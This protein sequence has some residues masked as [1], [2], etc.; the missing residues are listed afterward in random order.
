MGKIARNALKGYSYQHSVF[1]L[2]LSIMDTE[3]S[4]NKITVEA[5]NTKNFD[6][7]Y[8][9][10]VPDRKASR[11]TYR[12]QVKNYSG[13]TIEDISITDHIL[14]IKGDSNEFVPTDNNI[15]VVNTEQIVA[16]ESFMGLPCTRLKGIIIIPL[17]PEQIA[18]KLDNM[19][20]SET[21]ELQIIHKA[22]SIVQNA[23]F[24]ISVA[25]LPNLIEMSTDL[26]NNTVLLRKV[27]DHFEHSI[28]FIEGKP[29]VGKSHFVNEI[30]EKHPDAIVY[31]FWTG[32]QDPNINRRIQFEVFISELGIK[33]FRSAK[34]VL[35]EELID[36]IRREDKLV[37]FDGLDHVENYNPQ[38][39]ELFLDFINKLR[40]TRTVVLSRPLRHEIPWKKENLLDWTR[41]ETS[42][43]LEIA[44]G[45]SEYRI[46][47]QIFE[48]SGGYPIITYFLAEEF[49]LNHEIKSTS[50]ITG[51]NDYYDTLFVSNE[52]PSAAISIFATGNCFFTWNE[53]KS[54]FTE[55][56]MYDVIRE[57]VSNHPYLFRVIQN[58]ISLIHD[59]LNTYL[60]TKVD[61]FEQRQAKTVAIVRDSLLSGS[62]EYM[63]RMESFELDDDFYLEMIKK[64]SN[65]NSLTELMLSTRDYNSISSLYVQLQRL[66]E[67]RAGVL[68]IYEYYSFALLFQI[69]TRNDLFGHDSLVY[70]M[71]LYMNSH[72]GIEDNIFSSDYIWHVYLV[73]KGAEKYA[74]RYLANKNMSDSQFYGLID[75]LNKESIFYEK[76]DV[77]INYSEFEAVLK[78]KQSNLINKEN[79]LTDYLI[80]LWIHGKSGDKY[81]DVFKRYVAGDRESCAEITA[82]MSQYDLDKHWTRRSLNDA[83][84]QL[85]ELGFLEDNNQ[86]R[87][88]TLHELIM[89][90]APHG[91]FKVT[92]M[93]ASFLKLANH[94]NREIDISSLAYCWSMYYNRK[95]YSVLT[96]DE[97]LLTFES[98]GLISWEHSF[99][100]IDRLMEQ[101]EKGISH[102]LTS[103]VNKKD[104]DC[105]KQVKETGYF[106]NESSNIR[107]WDLNPEH[108]GC[109]ST[110][111]VVEQVIRLLGRHYYSNK[112]EGIILQNI[113]NSGHRDLVLSGIKYYNYVVLMPDEALIPML[114]NKGIEYE[115]KNLE[116]REES[117]PE[118]V[119]FHHGYI[120]ERDFGYIAEHDIGCMEIA[121]YADGWCSCLPF[122]DLFSLFPKEEIQENH[123][124]IIHNSLFARVIDDNFIGNW[125]RIIGNIPTFLSK[126]EIDVDW[127]KIYDTFNA[128]LDLSMINRLT[129]RS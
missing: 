122:V 4:I 77:V 18:D 115:G 42:V 113:V 61:Y 48:I 96:I 74:E 128:F 117:E 8:F 44:Y 46:Q 64:Y 70:Q 91:S 81:F 27:P 79:A 125:Y 82:D 52:K 20:F 92:N 35:I 127:K 58:R 51:I 12:V 9:E 33:V 66:L 15:L 107:F 6:D 49:K 86:F 88:S 124:G 120:S 83:E 31:R 2:F 90:N 93:A 57:F 63:A 126:Y 34:K 116:E 43:Y 45:I 50:P 75:C 97:A 14:S 111:E 19:F 26:E 71:L 65:A 118:Y 10:C 87:N 30:C 16:T 121:G 67:D 84:Y 104:S 80:S 123:I 17:T 98:K 55:P 62:V 105:V 112:V 100:I 29:G 54:F 78:D 69:A 25:E 24:E 32:S 114:D 99:A 41:D 119:P 3:R 72:E 38:Q 37:V 109:F 85:H 76:K 56:E 13:A 129:N 47:Q 103:Y 95:D 11:E 39:L 73:C 60:R 5:L 28:S 106:E 108:Y 102:L 1:L 7:I 101:S 89:K 23:K 40:T 53:I 110:S 68:D 36:A 59:S 21:R 94:E 22:D